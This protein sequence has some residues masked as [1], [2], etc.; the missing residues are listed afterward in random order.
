MFFFFNKHIDDIDVK[1]AFYYKNGNT[2]SLDTIEI[3][4]IINFEN[5]SL[6][7]PNPDFEYGIVNSSSEFLYDNET[8]NGIN[9]ST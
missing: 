2:T 1:S 6:N 5:L 8:P 7:V 9:L 4:E 3:N